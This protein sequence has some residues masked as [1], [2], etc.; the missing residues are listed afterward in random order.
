[1]NGNLNGAPKGGIQETPKKRFF[2]NPR[3]KHGSLATA[4]TAVVIIVIVLFNVAVTLIGERV[5]LRFDITANRLFSLTDEAKAYFDSV[6][7]DVTITVLSSE[8][9]MR[10]FSLF[11]DAG[12]NAAAFYEAPIRR[13]PEILSEIAKNEHITVKYVD[14]DANPNY[15]NKYDMISQPS[16][17]EMYMLVES[18][19]RHK[20][21]DLTEFINTDFNETTSYKT[22]SESFTYYYFTEQP[23]IN[24]VGYVLRDEV[25]SVAVVNGHGERT[26][27]ESNLASIS[28]IFENNGLNVE[29]IDFAKDAIPQSAKFLA[30]VA[31][32]RDFSQAEITKLDEFLQNGKD[33]GRNLLYF[34]GGTADLP[35]LYEY[36]ELNWGVRIDPNSRVYDQDNCISGLPFCVIT[37]YDS[38]SDITKELNNARVKT[39]IQSPEPIEVLWEER[40]IR[41]VTTL[42]STYDTSFKRAASE[43]PDTE[44]AAAIKKGDD[45][46]TDKF[47]VMTLTR[48]RN[49]NLPIEESSGVLVTSDGFIDF[50]FNSIKAG[51]SNTYGNGTLITA[52]LESMQEKSDPVTI[53]K[54]DLATEVI[55]LTNNQVRI[56]ALVFSILF[57]AVIIGVGTF[58]FVK[59][60]NL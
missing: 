43:T 12:A 57:P 15:L 29:V 23:L 46:I 41:T 1:M 47:A 10:D 32:Q 45:D 18:S 20:L 34:D 37:E 36:L 28:G 50:Y 6:E 39:I 24:A 58:V 19:K 21:V 33:Y 35:N 42:M 60:K 5:D 27:D 11:S 55:D 52:I 16:P 30:V 22:D 2:S 17:P 59:R 26:E 3:F 56:F 53:V 49:T 40:D 44:S 13:L 48:K 7:G 25:V 9:K 14:M 31:P 4:I 51:V 54:K 8:N 38:D